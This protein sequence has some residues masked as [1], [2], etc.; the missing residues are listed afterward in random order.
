MERIIMSAMNEKISDAV[1]E[2]LCNIKFNLSDVFGGLLYSVQLEMEK[3]GVVCG[4][5]DLIRII[6]DTSTDSG[7]EDSYPVWVLDE[8]VP[9][10]AQKPQKKQAQ[11]ILNTMT[12]ILNSH[13]ISQCGNFLDDIKD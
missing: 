5:D 11:K 1:N 10:Q 9:S 2:Q 13:G 4:I 6:V 8:R 7:H 12:K 3:E